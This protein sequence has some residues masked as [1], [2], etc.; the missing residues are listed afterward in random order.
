M[1]FLEF[2]EKLAI[3][4]VI[5]VV[6]SLVVPIPAHARRTATKLQLRAV[7]IKKITKY[8]HWPEKS[9]SSS[10]KIYT[11]AAVNKDEIQ[12]YFNDQDG[13]NIV[14][15][16]SESCDVLFFNTESSRDIA[17]VIK[18]ISHKPILTIGDNPEFIK[19]GGMINF[20]EYKGRIKLQVNICAAQKAGLTIS[21]KLLRLS[22]VFCGETPR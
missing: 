22:E 15:W 12:D 10:S 20:I 6:L 1:G 7:F 13:F 9:D 16:P 4:M 21:S 19:M 5:A 14:N 17:A 3:I 18:R 2:R 8:I 11:V